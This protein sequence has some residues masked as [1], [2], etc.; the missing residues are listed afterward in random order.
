VF[1]ITDVA[2]VLMP[3]GARIETLETVP[4]AQDV[5]GCPLAQ[6]TCQA[7]TRVRRDL[8]S[9]AHDEVDAIP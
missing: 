1:G 7:G 4:A 3:A 8:D 6:A 9:P 5:S 2:D